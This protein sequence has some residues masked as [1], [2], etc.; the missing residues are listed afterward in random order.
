MKDNNMQIYTVSNKKEPENDP[1]N[2]FA[3][4][5]DLH[6]LLF[7]QAK[8]VVVPKGG[9]ISLI[10]ATR[11]LHSEQ[12]STITKRLTLQICHTS[13]SML[14]LHGQLS[15]VQSLL[16]VLVAINSAWLSLSM[17]HK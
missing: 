14:D 8:W 1:R 3:L 5:R 6:S 7:D 13:S 11:L 2:L 16:L 10:K 15:S 4:R 12:H 17:N 9:I